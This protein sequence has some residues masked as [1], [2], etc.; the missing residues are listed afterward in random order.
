MVLS[1]L[2][3]FLCVQVECLCHVT[4]G[5]SIGRLEEDA[6]PFLL[7][8]SIVSLPLSVSHFLVFKVCVKWCVIVGIFLV[9]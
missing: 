1:G 7:S 2:L 6:L 3:L 8:F 4:I 9:C 5:A